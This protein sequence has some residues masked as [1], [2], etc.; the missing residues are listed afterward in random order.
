[1]DLQGVERVLFLKPSSLGDVIHALP[2]AVAIKERYPEKQ[3]GW[4]VEEETAPILKGNP[5]LSE[6]IVLPRKRWERELII[7]HRLFSALR[8]AGRFLQ[9]LRRQRYELAIDLQG[10]LKSGVLA[11]ASGARLRLG[12]EGGR[13][14]SHLFLT[15]RVPIGDGIEHAVDRYLRV[16]AYL[17]AEVEKREFPIQWGEEEDARARAFLAGGPGPWVVIHASARWGTKL[18]EASGFACLG[19]AL[20]AKLGVSVILTGDSNDLPLVKG[21]AERMGHRPLIVSGRTTLQELAALL[22]KVELMI[23]VDSGPMHMAAAL[24]TPVLALFGPTDPRRTGP[25]GEGHEVIRKGLECSPCLRRRCPIPD[26]RACMKSIQV[27]EVLEKATE[28]LGRGKWR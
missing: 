26:K 14:G 27:E 12:L 13:E 7:P 23:S 2:T 3:L 15:H 6:V 20:V 10:L 19:D 11:L 4:L 22:A 21:I 5:F 17:G 28:M 24:G 18:W 8:E 25:Y 9:G 16:A 1:L